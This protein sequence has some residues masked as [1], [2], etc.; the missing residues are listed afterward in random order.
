MA[1]ESQ[2]KR[3]IFDDH[4][5]WIPAMFMWFFVIFVLSYFVNIKNEANVNDPV[6]KV[7]MISYVMLVFV[8][9][10]WARSRRARTTLTDTHLIIRRGLFL[11]SRY[12]IPL[13]EITRVEVKEPWLLRGTGPV[14]RFMDAYGT[15][16]VYTRKHPELPIR[17]EN[18][19][20]VYDKTEKIEQR[21]SKPADS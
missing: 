6:G 10:A 19:R 14:W 4:P 3:I 20:Q 9:F 18:L 12:E 21:L 8:L 7:A 1:I 5:V 2:R 17:A 15:L 16:E 13:S 11:V